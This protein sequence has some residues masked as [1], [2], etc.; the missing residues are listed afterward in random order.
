MNAQ[1]STRLS[2]SPLKNFNKPMKIEN[3]TRIRP[4]VHDSAVKIKKLL[5]FS[6]GT[7]SDS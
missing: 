1:F 5:P 7:V 4:Q 6:K 2:F 3:E